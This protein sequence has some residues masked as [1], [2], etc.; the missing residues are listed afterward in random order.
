MTVPAGTADF[1]LSFV[2]GSGGIELTDKIVSNI[3]GDGLKNKLAALPTLTGNIASVARVDG[4]TT[5]YL[6]TFTSLTRYMHTLGAAGGFSLDFGASLGGLASLTTTGSIIPLARLVATLT[7]GINLNP[8]SAIAV[9]PAQFDPGRASTRRPRATV[10]SRSRSGR[11]APG[12]SGLAGTVLVLTVNGGGNFTVAAGGAPTT[13]SASASAATLDTAIEGLN[14]AFAGKVTVTKAVRPEGSVYTI[15]F[16][17]RPST[18]RSQ[19]R[20]R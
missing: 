15:N 2:N 16:D 6:I 17:L 11:S 14:G 19:A 20:S 12:V 13:V 9:G 7:F 3:T 5:A 10:A 1:W 8:T 18:R 4:D